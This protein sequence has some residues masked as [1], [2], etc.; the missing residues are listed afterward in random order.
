MYTW[1]RIL[2][3]IAV[4]TTVLLYVTG[5]WRS[6]DPAT[7]TD[8]GHEGSAENTTPVAPEEPAVYVK[9]PEPDPEPEEDLPRFE[10]LDGTGRALPAT[11]QGWNCVRDNQHG[12][13]WEVKQSNGHLRDLDFTYSWYASED[14]MGV[15]DGGDCYYI[16][17]DTESLV[18][19]VNEEG[20]C[21]WHD[22]RLPT[23]VELMTLDTDRLYYD[24]DIDQRYFPN[25]RSSYYWTSTLAEVGPLSWSVNFLNGFPEA[26]PRRLAYH[27]RLVRGR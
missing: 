9:E 1:V 13:V 24:P 7:T 16:F 4:F 2:V 19:A 11:A 26:S 14:D 5:L 25:T 17:C 22:W 23:N 12:L 10:K 18:K 6:P 20:L 3:L 21:G 15:A 27:V 8:T